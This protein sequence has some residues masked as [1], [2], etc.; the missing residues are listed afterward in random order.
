FLGKCRKVEEKL[1]QQLEK[2]PSHEEIAEAMGE[3]IEKVTRVLS[4]PNVTSLDRPAY[5]GENKTLH[6]IIG[7]EKDDFPKDQLIGE[8][9]NAL[10]LL[11]PKEIDILIKRLSLDGKVK[12][13]LNEIGEQYGITRQRV[14]Q[15]EKRALKKLRKNL[16]KTTSMGKAD[17]TAFH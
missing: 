11:K 4:G 12:V 5:Q 8:W 15:I 3:S 16:D 9:E 10:S 17:T 7:D 14:E 2:E 13:T 1:F 6:E